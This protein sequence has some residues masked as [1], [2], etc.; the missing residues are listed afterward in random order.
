[1]KNLYQFLYQKKFVRFVLIIA[2]SLFFLNGIRLV[3]NYLITHYLA[4]G[5][6]INEIN[7]WFKVFILGLL[8]WVCF[9]YIYR[10]Y[11][12][13]SLSLENLAY[14]T[15]F[16]LIYAYYRFYEQGSWIFL[17]LS[18]FN[19]V[20]FFRYLDMIFLVFIFKWTLYINSHREFLHQTKSL[21]FK[22]REYMQTSPHWFFILI[23]ETITIFTGNTFIQDLAGIILMLY[24]IIADIVMGFV[25]YIRYAIEMIEWA[26]QKISAHYQKP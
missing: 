25:A 1:M 17:P 15:F 9:F 22:I 21:I 19:K 4:S 11:Y 14:I 7:F 26:D 23:S 24:E 12:R 3:N 2:F 13:K 6:H 20:P 8:I 16:T 10:I 5:F 18:D